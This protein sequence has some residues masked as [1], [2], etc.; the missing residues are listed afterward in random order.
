MVRRFKEKFCVSAVGSASRLR[1]V[2]LKCSEDLVE[3]IISVVTFDIDRSLKCSL[4]NQ[5]I[6]YQS[7]YGGLLTLSYFL[8]Q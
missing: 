7:F 2:C 3:K 4:F 1:D 5:I 8:L 6:V